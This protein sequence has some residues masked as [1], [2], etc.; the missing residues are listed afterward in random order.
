MLGLLHGAAGILRDTAHPLLS[1]S[2]RSAVALSWSQS[3]REGLDGNIDDDDGHVPYSA[4]EN[5]PVHEMPMVRQFE[6]GT[7]DLREAWSPKVKVCGGHGRKRGSVGEAA[8]DIV[9]VF[10]WSGTKSSYLRTCGLFSGS[11]TRE[12]HI[13]NYGVNKLNDMS[14]TRQWMKTAEWDAAIKP[15]YN[16]PKIIVFNSGH[17]PAPLLEAWPPNSLL[18]ITSDEYNRFGFSHP[19]IKEKQGGA[20]EPHI[21]RRTFYGPHDANMKRPNGKEWTVSGVNV[22][23]HLDGLFVK[24]QEARFGV[25][26][27]KPEQCSDVIGL[28]RRLAI[29]PQ[30]VPVFKQYYSRR[31]VQS[32]P[33]GTFN[34]FPLGPRFEFLRPSNFPG[35][36]ISRRFLFN[37]I[38]SPTSNARRQLAAAWNDTAAAA[39]QYSILKSRVKFHI[40][41]EWAA[42]TSKGNFAPEDY[43]AILL[44]STFTLCPQGNNMDQFRI[45]EAI[46]SG[47]IPVIALEHG[48]ANKTLAP[49]TMAS[50]IV[51]VSQWKPNTFTQ[52]A[53]MERDARALAVRRKA[54]QQWYQTLLD[55][56]L[57]AL[58]STLIQ[59]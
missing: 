49:R 6:P 8:P 44:D 4:W 17:I 52:L 24:N 11:K 29:P 18:L 13:Y 31:H 30:I 42:D 7:S 56:T 55:E 22:T 53:E 20:I 3:H 32:F 37:F 14:S 50:P 28:V 27:I 23:G 21:R 33:S 36:H 51:F 34:W 2:A 59:S 41:H 26:E 12:Y 47:S 1:S 45:Y 35:P 10:T 39:A 15:F 58:E 16:E 40:A 43:A 38:G 9:R 48:L 25:C 46:E 19:V 54:L 57:T 5:T